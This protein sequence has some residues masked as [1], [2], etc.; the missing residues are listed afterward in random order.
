M[1]MN[2]LLNAMGVPVIFLIKMRTGEGYWG[3]GGRERGAVWFF[4]LREKVI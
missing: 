3:L 2:P 1:Q 4:P